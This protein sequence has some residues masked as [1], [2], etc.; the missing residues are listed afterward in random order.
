[1]VTVAHVMK[2]VIVEVNYGCKDDSAME[3]IMVEGW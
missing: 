3:V 1:M 2:E